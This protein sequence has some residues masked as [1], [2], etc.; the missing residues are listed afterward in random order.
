MM[1][2]PWQTLDANEFSS[3]SSGGGG[4]GVGGSKGDGPVLLYGSSFHGAL[5]V[6]TILTLG[7]IMCCCTSW[8]TERTQSS[9]HSTSES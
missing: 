3:S 4:G 1:D 7:T 8:F 2:Q 6:S 5:D 9:F